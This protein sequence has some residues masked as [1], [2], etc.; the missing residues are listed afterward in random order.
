MQHVERSTANK[1]EIILYTP[2]V[3][4]RNKVITTLLIVMLCLKFVFIFSMY[5]SSSRT[6]EIE[7]FLGKYNKYLSDSRPHSRPY[8]RP[9]SQQVPISFY[10]FVFAKYSL[11]EKCHLTQT[12]TIETQSS[13]VAA[14]S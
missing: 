8:S 9:Y 2:F 10:S 7:C 3:A 5:I 6:H 13:F 12:E 11:E 1:L 14:I 4:S